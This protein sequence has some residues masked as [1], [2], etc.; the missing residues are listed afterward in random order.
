MVTNNSANA[1]N[2]QYNLIVGTGSAYQNI[3]PSATSG[4]P[5]V[6]QGAASNPAYSTAVV[7]GGGTSST[8][9]NINGAV[10]SGGTTTSALTALTLTNG[11]LV[12]GATGLAP[13]AGTLTAGSGI[14]ITNG[15]NSITI[16]AVGGGITWNEVTGTSQSAAVN[17]GYIANNASLVTVTLPSTAALGSIVRVVG[18]GTGLWKLL[19]NTGQTIH[20]GNTDSTVAGYVQSSQQYDAIEVVCTVANTEWTVANGPMGGN[21]TVA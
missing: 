3:A 20:F 2:S 21:F 17:N 9:F 7:A 13:A 14:S 12:I 8:S 15:A 6:S 16:A 5:L 1:P 11:Q 18:K 4:I 10:I 19:A